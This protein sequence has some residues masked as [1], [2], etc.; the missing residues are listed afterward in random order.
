[1]SGTANG[2]ESAGGAEAPTNPT[3]VAESPKDNATSADSTPQPTTE[4]T[5]PNGELPSWVAPRIDTL[6]RKL[7]ETEETTAARIAELERQLAE[8]AAGKPQAQQPTTAQIQAEA[9]RIAAETQFNERCSAIADVG[10]T[11][12]NDFTTQ[13]AKLQQI[14]GIPPTMLHAITEVDVPHTVLYELSKDLDEAFRISQLPPLRQATALAKLG[15]KFA[16]EKAKAAEEG[17]KTK[18]KPKE[19]EP[20][21]AIDGRIV[22]Q[23]RSAVT[24][25]DDERVSMKEWMAE[26][27]RQLAAQRRQA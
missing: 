5:K 15:V 13:I 8:A 4:G 10:K 17:T 19:S 1:M 7:R 22:G 26:R 25:L 20:L 9:Q 23:G 27:Q 24:R 3:Q 16:A 14:G 12:Y 6:T 2:Q 18:P 11:E 21:D